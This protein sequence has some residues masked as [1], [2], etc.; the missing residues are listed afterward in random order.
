MALKRI[1]SLKVLPK[2]NYFS[3]SIKIS[4]LGN[5]LRF[6][7]PFVLAVYCA[8]TIIIYI[9]RVEEKSL[10]LLIVSNH[11]FACQV[12]IKELKWSLVMCVVGWANC[13]FL[14]LPFVLYPVWWHH[15]CSTLVHW[16]LIK[17]IFSFYSLLIKCGTNERDTGE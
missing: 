17:E 11:D 9:E 16:D 1:E 8:H 4:R 7:L 3:F 13:N 14:S 5:C 2:L 15:M 6:L 12:T 10:F